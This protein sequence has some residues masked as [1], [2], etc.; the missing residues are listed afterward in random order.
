MFSFLQELQALT[1]VCSI[2][3]KDN[4]S[5]DLTANHE[6]W[7]S[8]ATAFT[9]TFGLRC[10][11]ARDVFARLLSSFTSTFD[12]APENAEV[13]L[14]FRWD[15]SL[16]ASTCLSQGLVRVAEWRRGAVGTEITCSAD[17][18]WAAAKVKRQIFKINTCFFFKCLAHSKC[19]HLLLFFSK[20]IYICFKEN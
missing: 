3:M 13:L 4:Y 1:A 2:S 11:R 18:R 9:T 7:R 19:V 20:Y 14:V 8:A 15:W 17:R 16:R 12:L 6:G 10:F 5:G